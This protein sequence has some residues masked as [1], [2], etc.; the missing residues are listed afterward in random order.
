MTEQKVTLLRSNP[1]PDA[2][3]SNPRKRRRARRNPAALAAITKPM[4]DITTMLAGVLGAGAALQL[5]NLFKVSRWMNVLA[6]A[7]VALAGAFVLRQAKMD[8]KV[9]T[10]FVTGG[11]IMTAAK[12]LHVGTNG[13]IGLDPGIKFAPALPGGSMAGFAALSP[14]NDQPNMNTLPESET[15]GIVRAVGAFRESQFDPGAPAEE[16]LLT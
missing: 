10:G 8:S 3:V 7:G 9:T 12:A 1:A 5:P 15:T 4:P 14:A 11:F 2:P 6:S 13:R 16:P